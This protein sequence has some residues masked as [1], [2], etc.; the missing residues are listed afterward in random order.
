MA[1]I[2]MVPENE[3][4]GRVK[5]IYDEIRESL[6]IDFVPNMFRVMAVRPSFLE[7][8]WNQVQAVMAADGKVDR[9][10]KEII[11]VAVS[12]VCGCDY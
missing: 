5:D 10:T 7:A 11:A 2:E 4:T 6:G 8:K 3:A 9:L 1:S 12:A